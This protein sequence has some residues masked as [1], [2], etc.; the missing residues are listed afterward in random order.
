M[1]PPVHRPRPRLAR[2]LFDHDMTDVDAG[3]RLG[4]TGEYVRLICLPFD[5]P[6]RRVPGKRIMERVLSVTNGAVRPDD[7]YPIEEILSGRAA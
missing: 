5:D 3:R 4:C 1:T 6:N 7:F 2:W